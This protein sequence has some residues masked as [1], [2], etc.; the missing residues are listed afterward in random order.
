MRSSNQAFSYMVS[1][2]VII[3]IIYM[4]AVVIV[5]AVL[6]V[7]ACV[8]RWD[9]TVLCAILKHANA[10]AVLAS[11]AYTVIAVIQD[12][13]VWSGSPTETPDVYVSRNNIVRKV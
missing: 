13:G 7:C 12:T 3:I 5:M 9:R 4:Y 10:P 11:A 1:Q 6:Q 8:T 2:K